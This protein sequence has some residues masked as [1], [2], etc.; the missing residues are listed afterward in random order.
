MIARALAKDPERRYPSAG[1]LGRAALAAAEGRPVTESE[2]TVARGAAA[3]QQRAGDDERTAVHA[4]PRAGGARAQRPDRR[5]RV[6]RRPPPLA[7]RA[8]ARSTSRARR[9]RSATARGAAAGGRRPA[10]ARGRGWAWAW[11]RFAVVQLAGAGGGVDP[12]AAAR[13]AGRR[14]RGRA[15]SSHD[16]ADAYASEDAA[17]L[18][19]LLTRDAER[20]VPGARQEGRAAGDQVVQ[21]PVRRLRHAQLR[22]P[23]PDGDGRRHRP[24]ERPL[25]RDLRRR[26]RRHRHDHVRRAARPRHAADRADLGPPGPA[27][28]R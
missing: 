12:R 19:R 14:R 2:R 17:A 23:G 15:G 25:R 6:D 21:A 27:Q 5:D 10:A 7:R 11:R 18:G 4:R 20:V 24:G 3:P 1:D 16:F 26:A 9:C 28:D 22:G 8:S 13:R